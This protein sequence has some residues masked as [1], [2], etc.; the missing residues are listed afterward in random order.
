MVIVKFFVKVAPAVSVTRNSDLMRWIHFA[1]QQA[2]VG[3]SDFA[4]CGVDCKTA[5]GIIGQA[6]GEDFAI[7]RAVHV[8]CRDRSNRGAEGS[9]FIHR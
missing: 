2:A 5:R 7:G 8:E 9:V 4:S 3:D 6:V 1:I